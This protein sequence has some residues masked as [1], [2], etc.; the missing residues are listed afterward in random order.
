MWGLR[1]EEAVGHHLLNLDVGLAVEQVRPMIRNGL[2][3]AVD[4]EV[5]RLEAVNRRGRT[6]A[7]QVRC[8]ALATDGETP[9]VIILIDEE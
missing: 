5:L 7:V 4:G 3:G 6:I 2:S 8:E 1:P 9:G